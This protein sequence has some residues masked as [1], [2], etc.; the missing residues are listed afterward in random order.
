MRRHLQNTSATSS[1]GRA[2]TLPTP[3]GRSRPR[4]DHRLAA[5]AWRGY[6]TGAPR[7]DGLERIGKWNL[8][9]TVHR[10]R[11]PRTRLTSRIDLPL[12]ASSPGALSGPLRA[13]AAGGALLNSRG[14]ESSRFWASGVQ[15]SRL[16]AS[17]SSADPDPE[18]GLSVRRVRIGTLRTFLP[19]AGGPKAAFRDRTAAGGSAGPRFSGACSRPC[20]GQPLVLPCALRAGSGGRNPA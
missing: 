10:K 2:L 5:D 15:R 11:R 1:P 6:R 7:R 19:G 20:S 8:S 4:T 17:R 9:R 13:T 3:T 12:R 18:R 16:R 14:P